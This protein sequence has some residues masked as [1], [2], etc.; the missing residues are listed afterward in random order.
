MLSYGLFAVHILFLTL[1]G[2]LLHSQ[3]TRIGLS[4]L[5]FFLSALIVILNFAD[6]L[7]IWLEPFPGYV[8]R[9]GGHVHVPVILM[10]V[11]LLYIC[12][13]TQRAQL[14]LYAL[15]GIN[16]LVLATVGF[17]M[18]YIN[19]RAETTLITALVFVDEVFTLAFVR[20]VAASLVAFVADVFMIAIVCQGMRNVMRTPDWF[21]AGVALFVALW[22][23]AV[24]FQLLYFVGTPD[25]NILLPGDV[26]GKTLAAAL[27]WPVM[28]FYITAFAPRIPSYQ[29][30]EKRPTFDMLFGLF[31]GAT[32]AV[33]E[34]QQK[35]KTSQ[36]IYTQLTENIEE[37]FWLADVEAGHIIYLSPAFER[38][39][40]Y[41]PGQFYGQANLLRGII[42]PEDRS[43]DEPTLLASLASDHFVFRIVRS[44]GAIR[45]VRNRAFPITTASRIS[46]YAGIL[47][48]VTSQRELASREQQIAT[49]QAQV[50]ILN[51]F[52]RDASHD[53]KNPLA[54]I[55]LKVELLERLGNR[56]PERQARIIRELKELVDY[57]RNLID[58]LF[59]LSRVQGNDVIT[60]QVLELN[61]VVQKLARNA[62]MQAQ[63]RGLAFV[64]KLTSERTR[65]LANE[66]QFKR[67]VDNLLNNAVRYTEAGQI[68]V[69]TSIEEEQV[70]LR[71]EDTG[72]GIALED[73]PYIFERFYR[74][75]K[76]KTMQ[77]QG[78]GLGLAICKAIVEYSGGTISVNS[79]PGK[80]TVFTVSLPPCLR[81]VAEDTELSS[82]RRT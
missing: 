5:I 37:V 71:V 2:L 76:A 56:D 59:T 7:E 73:L 3:Q 34:L 19:L 21:N 49:T 50:R 52:I 48:D 24:V 27:I 15:A 40:G 11:L 62:Q 55:L 30:T 12:N 70:V 16:L 66:R 22:V 68:T 51:D 14:V 10:L 42:H 38:I 53:L 81:D 78:T 29:G 47:E 43:A 63:A 32:D 74:S 31:G 6:M 61:Q 1:I 41:E 79:E 8:L 28:G 77:S 20:G 67:V 35:L 25:F 57:Q 18:L 82:T 26:V 75:E 36:E 39:T 13:G 33:R 60:M 54:S 46:R 17:L 4:P 69:S 80:G 44:D 64:L 65:I 58:D 45:W 72:I 9:T 23:D